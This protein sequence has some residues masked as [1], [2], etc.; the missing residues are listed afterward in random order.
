MLFRIYIVVASWAWRG[1]LLGR[2]IK[3]T[4]FCLGKPHFYNYLGH[5]K[6]CLCFL[7]MRLFF[8]IDRHQDW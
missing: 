8:L 3:E 1:R 2:V 4:S 6:C 5:F 7:K